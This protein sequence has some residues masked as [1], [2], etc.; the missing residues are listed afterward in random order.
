MIG[1]NIALRY[2]CNTASEWHKQ[3]FYFVKSLSVMLSINFVNKH[4]ILLLY[5]NYC[6]C[7]MSNEYCVLIDHCSNEV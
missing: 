3:I 7:R 5:I 4:C 1:K 6:K 2:H